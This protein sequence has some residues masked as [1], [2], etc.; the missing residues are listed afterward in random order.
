MLRGTIYG[1]Q[2]LMYRS[3][4]HFMDRAHILVAEANGLKKSFGTVVAL[5]GLDL[6]VRSGEVLGLIGPSG[7]GKTSLA[8]VLVG[9]LVPDSGE[10]RVFGKAMPARE[11]L[12]RVGYMAQADAL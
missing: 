2:I 7:S 10:T 11:V 9:L 6:F 8:R 5:D 4:A 1:L 3:Y 12:S